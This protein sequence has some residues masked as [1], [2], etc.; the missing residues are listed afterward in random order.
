MENK[1]IYGV[2][3]NTADITYIMEDT[4][5]ND[6]EVKAQRLSALYMAMRK[7]TRKY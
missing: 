6:G 1:K 4:F 2:Y 7:I 5:N 3:A